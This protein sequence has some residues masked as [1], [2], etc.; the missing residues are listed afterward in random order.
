MTQKTLNKIGKLCRKTNKSVF[1][2]FKM[3]IDNN[4]TE[5]NAEKDINIFYEEFRKAGL[6]EK[7]PKSYPGRQLA[8]AR[9]QK[10]KSERKSN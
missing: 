1:A 4:F 8:A 3:W 7:A 10:A 6:F 9:S 5:E 2:L